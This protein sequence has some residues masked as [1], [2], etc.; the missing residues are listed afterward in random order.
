M[1]IVKPV[2]DDIKEFQRRELPQN[3]VQMNTPRSMDELLKKAFPIAAALSAVLF[4]VM[5]Y[6]DDLYRISE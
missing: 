2:I 1:I 5:F 3:A 4:V 6:E